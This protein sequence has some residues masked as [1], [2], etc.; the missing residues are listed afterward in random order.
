MSRNY[1]TV[2]QIER[3]LRRLPVRFPSIC[4]ITNLPN[5]THEGRRCSVVE[6]AG[7]NV[8]DSTVRS[9]PGILFTG[10]VHA[11]E[12]APPDTLLDLAIKIARA[13]TN[14]TGLTF[15]GKSFTTAQIWNIINSKDLFIF[16]LVNPDGQNFCRG[17]PRTRIRLSWRKNRR[18][19]SG[20]IRG[21]DINRNFDFL[22]NH[23]VAYHPD[24]GVATSNNQSSELYCGSSAFSEAESRNVRW[25]FDNFP[26]I[27]Y[28][29]DVHSYEGKVLYSW[30]DDENQNSQIT[31]NF[32]SSAH[33]GQRGL[34]SIDPRDSYREY[35]SSLD[36][37]TARNLA[38][39]MGNAIRDAEGRTYS[40]EQSFI[41]YPTSG[42]S[43]DYAFSRQFVN[44]RNTKVFAYTIECGFDTD[45]RFWPRRDR[46]PVIINEICAALTQ[47]CLS[48]P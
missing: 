23:S 1:L 29:V 45:G 5:R 37:N 38:T 21:V 27:R 36:E 17:P 10:G 19:L 16:P 26:N 47:F 25:L 4:N 31:M 48:I 46:L 34:P 15:G 20:S 14:N 41:L 43:D 39:A 6:I 18:P 8:R 30:G 12:W 32:R 13:Y 40:V 9:R 22:F 42:A 11:R 28:F 3:R 7:P 44:S 35:I 2:R 33:N 24:S